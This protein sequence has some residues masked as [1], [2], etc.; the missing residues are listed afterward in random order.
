MAKKKPVYIGFGNS[1]E[2]KRSAHYH[3]LFNMRY[4]LDYFPS[5]RKPAIASKLPDTRIRR[6]PK[7]AYM[8]S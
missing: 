2:I 6:P 8:I 3:A 5:F 7:L 1:F 4:I